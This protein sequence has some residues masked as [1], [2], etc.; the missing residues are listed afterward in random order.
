MP[1][2]TVTA[3]LCLCASL[4][5]TSVSASWGS[6]VPQCQMSGLRLSPDI[7]FSPSFT[8]NGCDYTVNWPANLP[9]GTITAFPNA[10]ANITAGQS[11]QISVNLGH[12]FTDSMYGMESESFAVPAGQTTEV[13]FRI[14]WYGEDQGGPC[15]SHYTVSLAVLLSEV[16]W[17]VH[18][19][20]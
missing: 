7:G 18:Q 5:F 13:I 11:F 6:A 10:D 1:S 19:R 14:H 2:S 16:E 8:N 3:L 12:P 9:Y 20:V 17:L 4:A 15:E